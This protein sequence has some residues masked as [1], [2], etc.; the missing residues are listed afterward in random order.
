MIKQLSILVLTALLFS[1]SEKKLNVDVKT[2]LNIEQQKNL[3]YDVIRYIQDLPRNATQQNKFDTI[4]DAPYKKMADSL[5]ILNTYKNTESDTLYFAVAKIAPSLKLKKVATVGKLVYD[6]NQKIQY[7]EEA[8]RT[9]K[10]EVPELKKTTEMLF[11]K[12][13]QGE[14]LSEFYTKNSNGKFIIEF[15]DDNNKYD[16]KSRQWIFNGNK[17]LMQ[18]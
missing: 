17:D 15:P 16:T 9:W 10:M 14:D 18:N 13:I 4:F 11:Q 12:F 6:K 1:C 2:H 8:F 3:K 5:D 7:Y